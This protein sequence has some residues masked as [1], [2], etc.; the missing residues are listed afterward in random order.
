MSINLVRQLPVDK[1]LEKLEGTGPLLPSVSQA[2][3]RE[4]LAKDPESDI[5]TTSL[6]VSL[7]CPVS[8]Y[9]ACSYFEVRS[10]KS[11]L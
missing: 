11:L 6:K 4:K 10:S 7:L 5:S 3:I 8:S 2:L 1:L 9:V